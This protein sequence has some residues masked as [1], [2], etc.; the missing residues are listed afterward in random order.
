[1]LLHKV[2]EPIRKHLR[3]RPDTIRCIVAALVEGDELSDENESAGLIAQ[4]NDETVE[5]FLDPKWEPEPVDAAPGE[6]D[7]HSAPARQEFG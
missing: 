1:V 3:D 2:A 7:A 5:S 6:F 4:S